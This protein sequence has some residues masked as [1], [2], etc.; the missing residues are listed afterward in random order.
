MI[1]PTFNEREA[2]ELFY[3]TLAPVVE[4]LGGEVVVVDDG[5]PDGTAEFARAL[6]GPVRCTV[7]ERPGVRGLASAVLAGIAR[8]QG[9]VLAVMD[10]DGS[11][12]PSVL[13]DLVAAVTTGGTELAL[14]SR[15]VNGGH[16]PGLTR[17]RWAESTLAR[18][19]ARPLTDVRDPMS[20]FFAVRREVLGRA[21]L[22]PVGYKI[23]LE[24]LVKC[25]P[26][27]Y[28]EIPFVFE[29]RLAGESKLGRR[30]IGNYLVHLARLYAS[31]V[32]AGRRASSTR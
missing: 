22:T 7:I 26:R 9:S 3:P 28:V 13:P 18:C 10:A 17:V 14:G 25:R 21:R 2:L 24:I 15:W 31:E 12:P 4:R 23:A 11:H 16:A 5:S 6:D 20:G 1:L 27:P 32:T 30:V 19:I 29:R 8:A